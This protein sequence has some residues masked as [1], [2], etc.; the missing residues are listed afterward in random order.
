M[1]DWLKNATEEPSMPALSDLLED[2]DVTPPSTFQPVPSSPDSAFPGQDIDS[3]F[4][5]EMPDW[6]S[7]G[8]TTG[9]TDSQKRESLP[10][11]ESISPADL[12]SWVQA[13]RPVESVIS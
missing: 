10:F 3:L 7:A 1:P 2:A 9:E 8:E 6:L 4:S 11:D 5:A 13:M 12:P